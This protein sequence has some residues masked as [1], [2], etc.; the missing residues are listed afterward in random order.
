M[1][2]ASLFYLFLD[3][4]CFLGF[5]VSCVTVFLRLVLCFRMRFGSFLPCSLCSGF[6]N[7]S[8]L[9]TASP[10]LL[11]PPSITSLHSVGVM[12]WIGVG[13]FHRRDYHSSSKTCWHNNGQL[14][15]FC[16]SYPS[17]F[18]SFVSRINSWCFDCT[19]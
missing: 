2:F 8:Q 6:F 5:L 18:H 12:L 17:V 11:D 19:F 15:L 10:S 14:W 16:I 7:L 1:I 3:S 9:C 13:G 4:S